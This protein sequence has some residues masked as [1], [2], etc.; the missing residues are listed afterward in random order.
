MKTDFRG[1][2]CHNWRK[3]LKGGMEIEGG[4]IPITDNTKR[5][6]KSILNK[7]GSYPSERFSGTKSE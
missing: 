1:R 3:G 5:I 7:K 6:L 2:L 4:N